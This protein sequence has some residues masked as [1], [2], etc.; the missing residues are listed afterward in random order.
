MPNR[1]N[2][3]I[4]LLEQDQPIYYTGGHTGHVLTYEQGK[5]DAHTWADYI[6][7]GME[8]GSFDMAG[9]ASYLN[10]LVDGGPTKS[11]HRTPA[12]IVEAVVNGTDEPNVRFNSWQFRQILAR[13]VHGILLCQAES[14]GAVRA[15]VEACRYPHHSEGVD[16]SLPAP[17][18]RMRG[19]KRETKLTSSGPDGRPYLGIGMRGK[20]SES[21]AA[22]IWG[23]K[24]DEYLERCDP[25]PLN[26]RGEL[27]LGVKLESPEGIANCEEILSVPGLG[28][29]ELGP[30]DLSLSLGYIQMPR[31]PFPPEMQEAR[32]RVF[33]ACRKYKIPFLEA[34]TSENIAAR[35]DEGVRVIA[36]GRE[37][38]A[39]IGRAHSKR[40][41]PF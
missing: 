11:G 31:D 39:K 1:I 23:V 15:F 34:A 12:I 2:R 26:P 4:E 38:T 25:W 37:E 6:N 33:A 35:I 22:P 19:A 14:L 21:T 36:G 16:P 30:G 27:L 13:G 17:L 3:A 18:E 9:L 20:G 40:T 41:M 29:A 24:G 5:Q 28:F 32:E 7:V 8:H 10:G